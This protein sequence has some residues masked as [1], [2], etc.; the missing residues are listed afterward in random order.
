MIGVE[1]TG[2]VGF[3]E[4][5]VWAA[6]AVVSHGEAAG[7]ERGRDEGGVGSAWSRGINCGIGGDVGVEGSRDGGGLN[8][9]VETE[10][11][12]FAAGKGGRGGVER[13]QEV[14]ET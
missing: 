13:E 9:G 11:G 7:I 12:G 8:R 5:T 14:W 10:R 4:G 1:D 6:E 3:I 2:G